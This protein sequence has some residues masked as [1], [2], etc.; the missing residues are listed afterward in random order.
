ME[1]LIEHLKHVHGMNCPNRAERGGKPHDQ[2]TSRQID[3]KEHD[4]LVNLSGQSG[5]KFVR[6][7]VESET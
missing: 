6:S 5:Y 7:F 4:A 1:T 2:T 3:G